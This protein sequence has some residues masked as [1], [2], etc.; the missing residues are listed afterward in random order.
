MRYF[1]I[2]FFILLLLPFG[3]HAQGTITTFAGTGICAE[4]DTGLAIN[5]NICDVFDLALDDS[6]NVY[7]V[8]FTLSK[9]RKI[10]VSTGIISLVAGNDTAGYSG[11]NDLAIHAK[12]NAPHSVAIDHYGDVLIAD[13]YNNRI[14]K[15]SQ[16]TGIITTIAGTGV[17]G[18]S[19]DNM[20]AVLA[21]L[22]TPSGIAVDD[23]NNVFFVDPQN[24]LIRKVSA[25]TGIITT[26]AGVLSGGSTAE[27][28][29]ATQAQLAPWTLFVDGHRNIFFTEPGNNRIRKVDAL[30][31][32]VYTVAGN[33]IQGSGGD[34]GPAL[35]A[36]LRNPYGVR[37]DTAG[38]VY[39]ADR[40]NQKIRKVNAST[41]IITTIAGNGTQGFFGDNGNPLNAEFYFPFNVAVDFHNNVY[42]ADYE[43]A[44]IRKIT[45]PVGIETIQGLVD[46]S[47]SPNPSQGNIHINIANP[48]RHNLCIYNN[49]GQQ[50]Y[51]CILDKQDTSIDLSHLPSGTYFARVYNDKCSET[52]VLSIVK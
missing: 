14:R 38:N 33:G 2:Y 6:G 51:T 43:N 22:S 45:Y 46:I 26:V 44:R 4:A 52:Q 39:I 11:D 25:T 27:G 8:D 34:N 16:T 41:G 13:N 48:A 40:E 32:N 21:E 47:I 24:R 18:N 50:V 37:T 12:L 3:L 19:G 36:S 23:S 30:T 7:Y 1:L 20:P 31:G 15:V 9:I 42:I 5:A 28:I 10:T 35:Q 17:Y 49:I 29:I